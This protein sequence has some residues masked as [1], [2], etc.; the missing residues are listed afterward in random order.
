MLPHKVLWMSTIQS[1]AAHA[2]EFSGLDFNIE[3]YS[4][5]ANLRDALDERP[6]DCVV[7]EGPVAGPNRA[8]CLEAVHS[9]YRGIP[10]VFWDAEM[11]AGEA[12]R[13]VR[14]GA[15]DCI[16]YRD[17]M[18]TLHD[19]ISRAVEHGHHCIQSGGG[20]EPWRNL[21]IGCSRAMETVA[22][23]IRLVGPRRC[24]VLITG[25]SG[26][27]K[28]VAA[29]AIH[30]ASPRAS[31]PMVAVNCTALPENL[32]EAE[33]FGHVKGA[34]TGAAGVR[35]GRF[36]QA[37]GGTVFLDEVGDMPIELQA[38]LL[39]VLQEREI[40][41]LGSS[42]TIRV[43]VRV[44]AATNVN[45][46]DRV[47]QGKFRED[48]YYR[49]NVFPFEMP[50]LRQHIG[51]IPELVHHFVRKVCAMEGIPEK[52]VSPEAIEGLKARAWPGNVRQLENAVEMAVTFGGDNRMLSAFDF[53]LPNPV[54]HDVIR[55]QTPLTLEA[56]DETGDFDSA[57]TRF[58]R[59]MIE[60]AMNRASGNK[61]AAAELLGLKRTT[62]IMKLRSF[63]Q[64]AA[65]RAS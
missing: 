15:F 53:R 43:D 52:Q 34:F 28:E 57:V 37:Q 21:L 2:D 22:E 41:R 26:T 27:G 33:L 20:N 1:S 8:D 18:E 44:I 47:R 35:I 5:I 39:R 10:V 31:R 32:L 30:A 7:I 55:R 17:G 49:L 29:R 40:Q 13:L 38:K 65:M 12:A 3:F 14:A 19:V 4:G 63:E 46:L 58:E 60:R 48:L 62:L 6:A 56:C 45:L 9:V 59:T 16:G 50:P 61:T 64:S 42:E 25:E 36:E 11:S 24:T 51:D 23:T 54:A